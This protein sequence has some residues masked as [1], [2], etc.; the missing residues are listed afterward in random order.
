M[1]ARAL[2]LLRLLIGLLKMVLER[3]DLLHMVPLL[4]QLKDIPMI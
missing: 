3:Q 1:Q 2:A 4:V